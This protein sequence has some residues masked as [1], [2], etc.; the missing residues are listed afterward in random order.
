MADVLTDL[1]RIDDYRAIIKQAEKLVFDTIR[2]CK[3]EICDLNEAMH[4]KKRDL[5]DKC[6]ELDEQREKLNREINECIANEQSPPQESSERIDECNREYY[7]TRN[8]FN[9]IED[10]HSR[11]TR[12]ICEPENKLDVLLRQISVISQDG[13]RFLNEYVVLVEKILKPTGGTEPKSSNESGTTVTQIGF[14]GIYGGSYRD[15]KKFSSGRTG[16]EEVHHIPS[17]FSSGLSKNDGPAITMSKEDHRE[18]ASFD[19]KRGAK[20]HREKQTL[21][22]RQG[23]FKE[24]LQMDI[25]DIHIKFKNK[26]DDGIN[27]VLLYVEQL[28]LEGKI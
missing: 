1:W 15:C 21:L 11:F 3:D 2:N 4:D 27:E 23:K 6:D 10:L 7:A 17:D 12:S 28:I 9:N 25:D 14:V 5:R 26:Y 22:I 24:A 13:A 8:K 18:T 19:N 16:A 20:A